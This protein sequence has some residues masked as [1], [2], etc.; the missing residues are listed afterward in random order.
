MAI[1][2]RLLGILCCPVS[3]TPVVLLRKNQIDYLNA[4]IAAG[5]VLKTGG[6]TI[7]E[8][9]TDGLITQD[10]KVVYR[11]DD[12]I[13]VMLPDEGIATVQFSDF[14]TA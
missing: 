14:P 6:E 11:I 9:I 1:D 12:D 2:Q 13:P 3:K 4:K 7:K 10:N 8:P 5:S